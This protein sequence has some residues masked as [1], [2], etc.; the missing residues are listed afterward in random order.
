MGNDG[1]KQSVKNCWILMSLCLLVSCHR[2]SSDDLIEPDKKLPQQVA[3]ATDKRIAKMQHNF[4]KQGVQ[5]IT[6]GQNYLLSIPSSTLFP[7]QSPQLTWGAHG[8]L[9][10]VAC[11]LKEFRKISIYVTAYSSCYMSKQRERAL[12]LARARNVADYLWEQGVDARFIFTQGIGSDKPILMNA[13]KSDDEGNSRIEITF[14]R[15][16][17]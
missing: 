11:Y 3:G 16:V 6:I 13:M 12:T 5:L 10:N 2:P 7:N 1:L 15:A 9:N 8:V 4:S 17:V 14:R